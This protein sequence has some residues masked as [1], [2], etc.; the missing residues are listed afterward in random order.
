MNSVFAVKSLGLQSVHVASEQILL[1]GKLLIGRFL[2]SAASG[3]PRPLSCSILDLIFCHISEI[4]DPASSEA[5][6]LLLMLAIS[7]YIGE[8]RRRK[9]RNRRVKSRK[10]NKPTRLLLIQDVNVHFAVCKNGPWFSVMRMPFFSWWQTLI[11]TCIFLVK[12]IGCVSGT[13]WLIIRSQGLAAFKYEH[14]HGMEK[15][16]CTPKPHLVSRIYFS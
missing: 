6:L 3:V 14:G 11:R 16:P 12:G 1:H 7:F 13:G 10:K 15:S 4:V 9:R 2:N 5:N 8:G